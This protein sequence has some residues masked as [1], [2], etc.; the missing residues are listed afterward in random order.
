MADNF[1][2][3]STWAPNGF[4]NPMDEYVQNY[5]IRN[6]LVVPTLFY[7]YNLPFY[8]RCV[9]DESYGGNS[10]QYVPTELQV[11]TAI[12]MRN[13]ASVGQ[14]PFQEKAPGMTQL[15]QSLYQRTSQFWQNIRDAA[16]TGWGN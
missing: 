2:G 1:L 4:V 10:Y 15:L 6:A 11:H 14:M 13:M 12:T 7:S 5:P 9:G 8:G 3:N 16:G